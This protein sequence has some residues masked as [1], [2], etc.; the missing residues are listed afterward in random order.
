MLQVWLSNSQN[1]GVYQHSVSVTHLKRSTACAAVKKSNCIWADL[2]QSW[3]LLN[4]VVRSQSEDVQLL[5]YS[6]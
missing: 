5:V 4:C 1:T 6:F 2:V 3:Q